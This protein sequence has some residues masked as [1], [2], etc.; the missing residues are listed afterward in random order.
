M[1]H[2]SVAIAD[3]TTSPPVLS[4]YRFRL[5]IM[6]IA[7]FTAC[8]LA[9]VFLFRLVAA[10]RQH[11][12]E[13]GKLLAMAHQQEAREDAAIAQSRLAVQLMYQ[14]L[15]DDSNDPERNLVPSPR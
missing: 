14:A 1:P 11:E 10:D 7:F 3:P 9:A 6:A 15:A 4:Q 12:R 2:E 8:G 5:R 13:A